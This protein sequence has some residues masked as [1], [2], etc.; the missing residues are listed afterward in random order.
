M[1]S[2]YEEITRKVTENLRSSDSERERESARRRKIFMKRGRRQW[3]R[4]VLLSKRDRGSKH[5]RDRQIKKK[6]KIK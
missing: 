6:I 4:R 2:N 3:R 5:R 1:N